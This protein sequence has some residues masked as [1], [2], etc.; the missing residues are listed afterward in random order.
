M[1]IKKV[2]LKN[3]DHFFKVNAQFKNQEFMPE[4]Q[5]KK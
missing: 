3:L 1:I 5:D 4:K 2:K